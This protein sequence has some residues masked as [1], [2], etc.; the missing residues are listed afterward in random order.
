MRYNKQAGRNALE[1][2]KRKF[3]ETWQTAVLAARTEI[4]EAQR[5]YNYPQTPEGVRDAALECMTLGSGSGVATA[6]LAAEYVLNE[7][8]RLLRIISC[9]EIVMLR[10]ME[11]GITRRPYTDGLQ[12]KVNLA[13]DAIAE[14]RLKPLDKE[15]KNVPFGSPF[16]GGNRLEY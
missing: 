1:E 12:E 3:P 2:V 6:L 5:K 16:K 13:W 4:R 11:S 9:C 8:R 14:L 10:R 7:S 15:Y